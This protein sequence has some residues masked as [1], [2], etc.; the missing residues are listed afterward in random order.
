MAFDKVVD[1]AAL[2]GNLKNVANA[3]RAKGKTT[4]SLTFPNGFISAIQTIQT[5]TE[6]KIVVSVTSGAVVTATKG[7][8]TVS[9]TSVN[10][11][12]T[13]VV[14]EAG[15]W[16]VKATLGGQTSGTEN[17]SVVDSYAVTLSF[18]SSTLNNNEW[19]VIKYGRLP[20][21]PLL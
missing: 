3:I 7:S 17:V 14:P 5:G 4:A 19:S 13:L 9:G 12:C 18:V 15:T 1:S 8:D 21:R 20:M 10:G 11:V 2:D 16:S 6:L